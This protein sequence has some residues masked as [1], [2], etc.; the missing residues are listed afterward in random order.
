M[1]AEVKKLKAKLKIARQNT[2][3]WKMRVDEA[4]NVVGNLEEERDRL[5]EALKELLESVDYLEDNMPGREYHTIPD[6]VL[7]K[8]RA[9]LKGK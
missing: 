2:R 3:S 7:S 1:N 6:D 5:R 9:A 8:A 4:A